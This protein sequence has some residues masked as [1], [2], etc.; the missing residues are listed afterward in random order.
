M[1]TPAHDPRMV[2]P[3]CH[4]LQP[5]IIEHVNQWF[6]LKNRG[7]YYTIEY[8]RPQVAILPVVDN[9]SIVMVRVK[10]PILADNPLE[11]PAGS[12]EKGEPP[13][14]AAER[15]FGEETGIRLRAL[16]RFH[17][18]PSL[19]ISSNRYPLL[20]WIYRVDISENEFDKRDFHDDEIVGLECLSFDETIEKIIQGEIYVSL[21]VAILSRFLFKEMNC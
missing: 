16:D 5:V 20:P 11:L 3:Q 15:E 19:A 2:E 4:S 10:R 17:P 21:V 14:K 7:G 12:A 6:S 13:I 1:K 8:H 18:L 9:H